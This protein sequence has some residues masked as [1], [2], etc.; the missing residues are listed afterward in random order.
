MLKINAKDHRICGDPMLA[1]DA[2]TFSRVGRFGGEP[3]F[4]TSAGR[5]LD[6]F[7]HPAE[8]LQ[9]KVLNFVKEFSNNRIKN[10]NKVRN[11]R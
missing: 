3:F 11:N 7:W 1:A 2:I 8:H 5:P 10:V 6:R 9:S 4:G